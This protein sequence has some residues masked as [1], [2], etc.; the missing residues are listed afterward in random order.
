[1]YLLVPLCL[2]ACIVDLTRQLQEA[3]NQKE[4]LA[5]QVKYLEGQ[6]GSSLFDS[7]MVFSELAFSAQKQLTLRDSQARLCMPKKRN[8]MWFWIPD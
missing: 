5:N 6:Q 1:M 7:N 3:K 4:D 8:I 2:N